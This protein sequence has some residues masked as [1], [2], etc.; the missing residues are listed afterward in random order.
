MLKIAIYGGT[1]DPVH[2][3]HIATALTIQKIFHF[4][5]FAFLPCKDPLL[6][7]PAHATAEQRVH[8]LTLALEN[9]PQFSI[10]LQ[11]IQRDS[12]SRMVDTLENLRSS[13]PEASITLI[14]GMDAFLNLAKWYEWEQLP[15][16]AHLLVINR[17][18]FSPNFPAPLQSLLKTCQ[19]RDMQIIN[20]EEQGK[21]L[22]LDAGYFDIS[23]TDIR[24]N[25]HNGREF[26]HLLDAKVADYIQQEKLYR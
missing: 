19:T 17:P 23:S 2:K 8:M 5:I 20:H 11:E 9:Y 4:N 1:F 22:F 13:Y 14:L 25:I 3:G 15:E 12:P 21:I 10:D 26:T 16:L 24:E 6:K 18:G 7:S